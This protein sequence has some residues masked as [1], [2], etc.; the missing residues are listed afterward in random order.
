MYINAIHIAVKVVDFAALFTAIGLLLA[1]LVLLPSEAFEIPSVARKW[2][3]LLGVA[4]MLLT[5]TGLMLFLVRVMQMSGM[6][7]TEAIGLLPSVLR[8]THFGKA[9][10]VHLLGLLVLWVCWSAHAQLSRRWPTRIMLAL[11]YLL[12]LTYSATS[13]AADAGDFTVAEWNDCVH[14]AAAAS[15]GGGIFA[16]LLLIAP[17]FF[18]DVDRNRKFLNYMLRRLS[19]VS[20][21]ALLFVVISGITNMTIR[22]SDL[23]SLVNSSYGHVLIGK[24]LLVAVM[25][26]IGGINRLVLIPGVARLVKRPRGEKSRSLRWL[27]VSLRVDA[28][29]V[30]LIL[31][32]ASML[33]QRM[34]PMAEHLMP[35]M[36][37][38]SHE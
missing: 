36:M 15:W 1:R 14:L 13:H 17:S 26:A 16:T 29:L 11:L 2:G 24:L 4:L 8:Q 7:S 33:I 38:H 19:T 6:R 37:K 18:E 28:I 10:T 31:T 5:I 12:T 9:W 30:L 20:A 22:L 3:R 27:L 23:D 25:V 34:P 35:R 32:A 21:T